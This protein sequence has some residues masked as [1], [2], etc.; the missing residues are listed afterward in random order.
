MNAQISHSR[1]EE[2]LEAKTRWFKS[3]SL[4]ERM[5]YLCFLTDIVLENNPKAFLSSHAES[6]QRRILILSEK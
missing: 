1:D 3:L 5:E 4:H 2:T 6:P